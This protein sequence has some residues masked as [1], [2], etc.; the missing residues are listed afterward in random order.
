MNPRD[1]RGDY[2]SDF[3]ANL[4]AIYR[5]N[6]SLDLQERNQ[7]LAEENAAIRRQNA[8]DTANYRQFTMDRAKKTDEYNLFNQLYTSFAGNKEA[9]NKLIEQHPL[10]KPTRPWWWGRFGS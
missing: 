4:P 5:A 7:E 10:M 3:L 8:I 9:Q 2:F 1:R 6:R